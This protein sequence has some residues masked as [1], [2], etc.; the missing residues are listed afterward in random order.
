MSSRRQELS[1]GNHVWRGQFWWKVDTACPTTVNSEHSCGAVSVGWDWLALPCAG[2]RMWPPPSCSS[3]FCDQLVTIASCAAAA[4]CGIVS[5]F[6]ARSK[7][8]CSAHVEVSGWCRSEHRTRERYS[9]RFSRESNYKPTSVLVPASGDV[10]CDGWLERGSCMTSLPL[11]RAS[12]MS[13]AGPRWRQALSSAQILA[14]WPQRQSEGRLVALVSA[15]MTFRR[16]EPP[17]CRGWAADRSVCRPTTVWCRKCTQRALTTDRQVVSTHG[18]MELCVVSILMALF[19][20]HAVL[21]YDVAHRTT[22]DG[23]Q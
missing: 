18:E 20:L 16:S 21:R 8:R 23:E 6:K 9:S 17:T 1:N 5:A 22:V 15:E 4:W 13:A 3:W 11:W 7:L 10:V 19:V 2:H 14:G 12:Q